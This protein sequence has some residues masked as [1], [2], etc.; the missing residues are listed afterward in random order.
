MIVFM[1][2]AQWLGGLQ[3]L[4]VKNRKVAVPLLPQFT[5][6]GDKGPAKI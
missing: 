3:Y 2:L 5:P 4:S 6:F 1:G